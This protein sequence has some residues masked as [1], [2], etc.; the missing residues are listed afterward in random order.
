MSSIVPL[1]RQACVYGQSKAIDN[2]LRQTENRIEAAHATHLGYP[3]NLVGESPV[4]AAFSG[5]LVN[6]LGDPYVGSH[7]GSHTCDLERE[8][9]AWLMDLWQCDDRDKF[10]GSVVA[11]GTEGNIWALYLA[12]EAFPTAKLLYSR[13]AHYSIPKAARILRMEGVAVDCEKGGAIDIEGFAEALD[14]LDGSPVIVA[15][16]CGTTVK[17]AHDDIAAVVAC[18]DAAGFGPHR[19]FIHVDGALNAM[20]LPFAPEAPF[21]IQPSFHHGI[22]SLSTS[23]HKMIGTPMPCGVL[24]ALRRHVDRVASAIAYLRSS[25]TTLMGSRN[26]HAVL[27]IWSRLIGHGTEGYRADVRACLARTGRLVA[28]MR[29][30]TVPV[31]CNPFS[32]TVVF[33]Q[34]GE[35]VVRTYQ[36]ACNKGEAHA[37]VMPNVTDALINR[38]VSDYLIWWETGDH[39]GWPQ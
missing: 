12:R 27:S 3:Y 15:L 7:F 31:L 1:K 38:F 6:N 22:D 30:S 39:Q 19:R 21:A 36:L 17:G 24:V 35:A 9:V 26:G 32:F 10:W 28:A 11:S 29:A 18:L 25:D 16:T 20:V 33:P 5:Y 2:I 13:E 34:P 8:A 23:G 37:I 4:P 14:G